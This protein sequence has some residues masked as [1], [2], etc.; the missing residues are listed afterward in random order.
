M[1]ATH[2]ILSERIFHILGRPSAK[3]RIAGL[4]GSLLFFMAAM[5]AGNARSFW[6]PASALQAGENTE[7]IA[8]QHIA[9]LAGVSSKPQLESLAV[10]YAAP[11]TTARLDDDDYVIQRRNWLASYQ[12]HQ[13]VADFN[14]F[15]ASPIVSAD[16]DSPPAPDDQP[17]VPI[18]Q[19]DAP[20]APVHVILGRRAK[21][22][23]AD[24]A[25]Q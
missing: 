20:L 23:R 12:N 24:R 4:A 11:A 3:P 18:P 21:A 14:H 7:A 10:G 16:L 19:T 25:G 6:R 22:R 15:R 8:S 17:V 5:A 9:S 1:A 13:T 2:G